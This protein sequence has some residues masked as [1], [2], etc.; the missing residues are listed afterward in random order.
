MVI[1]LKLVAA[2]PMALSITT[3]GQKDHET[4]LRGLVV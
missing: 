3:M 4:P 2:S 1:D